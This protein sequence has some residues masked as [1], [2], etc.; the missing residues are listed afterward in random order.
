[1]LGRYRA[2]LLSLLA[3]L[4]HIRE[5]PEERGHEALSL[6]L[7]ILDKVKYV[8]QRAREAGKRPDASLKAEY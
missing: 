5:A 8:E 7:R 3:Q 6:Q 2:T 1:M 4:Q